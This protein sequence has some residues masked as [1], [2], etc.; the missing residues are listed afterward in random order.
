MMKY[1]PLVAL[2]CMP[3]VT[4]AEGY[5]S[6]PTIVVGDIGLHCPYEITGSEPAPNTENGVIDTISGEPQVIAHTTTVPAIPDLGFGVQ[7]RLAEGVTLPGAEIVVR[8]P[9]MGAEGVTEQR[10]YPNF[11]DQTYSLSMYRFDFPYELLVGAWTFSVEQGGQ[12][13]FIVEFDVVPPPAGLT[14]DALCSGEGLLS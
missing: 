4:F 2:F 6:K 7:L 12:T 14:I 8:H 10:W 13:H 11:N 5:R 3:A 1:V 9:P